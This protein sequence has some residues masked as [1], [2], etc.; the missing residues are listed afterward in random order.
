M[1]VHT[2]TIMKPD[3]TMINVVIVNVDTNVA[4]Q[5]ELSARRSINQM[6]HAVYLNIW[7]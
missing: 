7:I 6:I 1:V 5:R 3:H 2:N 4:N